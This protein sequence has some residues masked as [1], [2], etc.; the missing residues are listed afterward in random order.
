MGVTEFV[1]A[2]RCMHTCHDLDKSIKAVT[3]ACN[4]SV[5]CRKKTKRQLAVKT[6]KLDKT[7]IFNVST[8]CSLTF[9]LLI[10]SNLTQKGWPGQRLT[11]VL[12]V[13]GSLRL[14]AGG[15]T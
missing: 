14:N 9:C 10:V 6:L 13:T 4:H 12:T 2:L 15:P 7:A 11:T 1:I 3:V 5:L 8:F